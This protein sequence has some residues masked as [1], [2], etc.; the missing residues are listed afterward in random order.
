MEKVVNYLIMENLEVGYEQVH[1]LGLQD[2]LRCIGMN[3]ITAIKM[4]VMIEKNFNITIDDDDL[5][6][7]NYVSKSSIIGLL[8]KYKVIE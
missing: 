8:K 5:F 4:A 1:M 2:D 6:F 3:S 7:E